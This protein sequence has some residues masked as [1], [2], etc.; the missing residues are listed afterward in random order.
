MRWTTECLP[1]YG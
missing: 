1:S